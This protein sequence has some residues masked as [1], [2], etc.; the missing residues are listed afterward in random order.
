MKM[1]RAL[2]LTLA[3]PLF[4]GCLVMPSDP[5][6]SWKSENY[7]VKASDAGLFSAVQT[8]TPANWTRE[9]S[10]SQFRN[11]TLDRLWGNYRL[12]WVIGPET[13][14]P[15]P[16]GWPLEYAMPAGHISL[17]VGGFGNG[18]A[19][20]LDEDVPDAD[21]VPWAERFLE[22]VTTMDE[23]D[24]HDW[25]VRFAAT[26]ELRF[27]GQG[28]RFYERRLSIDAPLKLE[29]LWARVRPE[30]ETHDD[31]PNAEARASDWAF[32]FVLEPIALAR[33]GERLEVARDDSVVFRGDW[34]CEMVLVK[35]PPGTNLRLNATRPLAD[36]NE[37]YSSL[38][39][40][41]PTDAQLKYV[42]PIY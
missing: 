39:R 42:G 28:R 40:P 34:Q 13:G 23:T 11:E 8:A 41:P 20:P 19:I 24:R 15:K 10:I 17:G 1:R 32:L 7:A 18:V 36:F 35:G 30:L 27:E 26:N 21:V 3:C 2:A 31:R 29:S 25:A 9:D 14:L 6:E 33:D 4:A 38:G 22:N 37:A 12:N 5:C 16:D